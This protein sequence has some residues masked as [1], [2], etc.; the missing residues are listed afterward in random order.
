ME[1]RSEKQSEYVLQ[2]DAPAYKMM[3][4]MGWKE[5]GIGKQ[6]Q[7]DRIPVAARKNKISILPLARDSRD[8][9]CTGTGEE[10]G[11]GIRESVTRPTRVLERPAIPHRNTDEENHT[12]QRPP[13]AI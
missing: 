4:A 12:E 11:T 10:V 7:G 13:H 5:G 2:R 1:I 6:L 8:L 9:F 3:L